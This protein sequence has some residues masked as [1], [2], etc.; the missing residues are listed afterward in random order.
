MNMLGVRVP[1]PLFVLGAAGETVRQVA[2]RTL[3]SLPA[4]PRPL[5]RRRRHVWSCPGRLYVEVHGVHGAGGERVARRVERAL[6]GWPGVLW[7]RVNAPTSRVI[8]AVDDPAPSRAELV[9]LVEEAEA[10]PSCPEEREAEDELHHPADGARGTR[11]VPTLA[12]DAFGLGL[13]VLTRIAPWAPLPPE[14][15]ALPA[16]ADHHPA[17]RDLLAKRA[18]GHEKADSAT[19]IAAAVAHGLAARSEGTLLD[20]AQRAVQWREARAHERAWCVKEDQLITGPRDA[21]ADP[22]VC[23]RPAP[24]PEGAVEAYERRVMALG[25]AA[26]AAAL[27]LGGPRRAVALGIAALPKAA[28]SGQVAFGAH[29]GRVL[30]GRGALVMGRGALRRMDRIS[31]VVLDDAALDT[32]RL[33]LHELVPLA[34]ADPKEVAEHAWRLLDPDRPREVRRDGNWSLGPVEAL[35]LRG[36]TGSRER[37][38]VTEGGA[39][40]VLGLAR[41]DQLMAV[42]GLARET[43][44][45]VPAVV[46]AARRGG[47]LVVTAGESDDRSPRHAADRTVPGG[48]RLVASVRELQAEGHGVLLVSSNRRALGASDCGLGVHRSG[49][50]PSWGAHVLLGTDLA[51][52]AVV[53]AAV[54]A[55]K[56]VNTESI[57]LAQAATGVGVVTA[58][59]GRRRTA[60]AARSMRSVNIGAALAMA[61]ALRHARRLRPPE[62]PG[63]GDTVPWH[64][65]PAAA[66]LDRLRST[67]DGLDAAEARRR[68]RERGIATDLRTSLGA[69]FLAE[70]ANPLTPVLAGGAALSAAVG[71]PVDAALVAGIT[72]LAALIGSIQQVHTDRELADLLNRSAVSANVLR[73][74]EERVVNA[75]ELVPGDVITLDAGDVVPADCRLLEAEGLEADESSL[76]G[77]SLPVAKDPAPVV[78]AN[79]AD[80][81]SMLYEGTTIAAGEATALVVAVGADTEAGR[82]MAMARDAAPVTG[83]ESRLA[84]LTEKSLPLAVGSAAA[85]A[86]A[87]LLRG[88]PLRQSLSAA[89]NL[90]VGSVPEG[91]PFLVNAAQL[92]AARRLA[93]RGAL[94]RNPRSI[95]ALGRVDVLCFD[96]TGTLT[97]GRLTVSEVDDGQYRCRVDALRDSSRAVL[98]AAL[99][100]TPQADD[101]ADLPHATDRAV[102]ASARRA[103]M[104][105]GLGAAG[106]KLV[107]AVPFEPSRGYHAAVG[108]TK[109]GRLLSVKGAPE[110]V[111]P[112]CA[113]DAK[114]RKRLFGRMQR[115]AAAG[116]R[117]LAVAERSLDRDVAVTETAVRDLTFR[118]FV[119]IADP[120][121]DSAAEAAARLR[122]AG[123]H[124]VMITGDHPATGEAVAGEVNGSAGALRVVTGSELDELDDAALPEMLSDVD[125]IARCSPAQKVRIIQAYQRLGRTVAMTGD[126]AND[127]PAIRLADVGIALGGHG[128]PAARAAADLVVTDDRLE[129]IIA[130]LAEGRAM[131]ASVREAL[132][133]LLGG[134][135]G[136]IAFSVLG[137]VVTG[138][139]PLN[140]RQLLLVNLL[141][142]LAPAMAIA[143][144]RPDPAVSADLLREGPESSL[145]GALHRDIGVRAGFTTLGATTA[146]TL[147]RFTGRGRRA[148]TVAL[149]AL[150]GTQLGQTLLTG[151]WN[152]SVLAASL[153]SA[154]A[155]GAVVQTPGVSQFFG[156]T[157]LGP[158][159]WSIAFGSATGASLLG[160][161]TR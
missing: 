112:R 54:S 110:S 26:G 37:R 113:L 5:S 108:E 127:A 47:L 138:R 16:I 95:E 20:V 83:V 150:V 109:K 60:P 137:A 85:V 78:A 76:T 153:G 57:R 64:L 19:S 115:L 126:G 128:T 40:A 21:A 144:R 39:A 147:A 143:L 152:R 41:G 142:D 24:L 79:V 118:G 157:P 17:L 140:A 35:S 62:A 106:W 58:L 90:A 15:A 101:P 82:S 13:S 119:A 156:C 97:E 160:T 107:D 81:T 151:G 59:Q 96:K 120:V 69:A 124:I 125:V 84:E 55:A 49:E 86:G 42:L 135:L 87:G 50:P 32:G 18:G 9:R 75:G 43:P 29:L 12:V 134:N 149:A 133:V 22:V 10:K 36:R 91:L 98:A 11:L 102:L 63:A 121:R 74:G 114:A 6:D 92:A 94:V 68:A 71:S 161:L 7:A 66:A 34:G 33:V 4:L 148:S 132:G 155:L 123:V 116:Q 28:E 53:V 2:D 73:D 117:V 25:A 8:V 77:E 80:R 56:A 72:G 44:A 129:T 89:V 31:A 159:G 14:L 139:S 100:A 23:E 154:V 104:S 99:R 38:G 3:P 70:L 146:W 105:P 51:T 111:L 45:G 88:V 141:T 46:A 65:M 136:E 30:A 122:D 145:G 93:D 158:I 52:A 48:G 103:R 61:N 27:P 67:S 1:N 131:W 130:A